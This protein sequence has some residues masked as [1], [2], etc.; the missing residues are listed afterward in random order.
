MSGRKIQVRRVLD[1]V[2]T[3]LSASLLSVSLLAAVSV[4]AAP[5]ALTSQVDRTSP[6]AQTR[7]IVQTSD[8]GGATVATPASG[9]STVSATASTAL[10]GTALSVTD[11]SGTQL[12]LTHPARR[13]ISLAPHATELIYAAGGGDWLVGA[14]DYS[15]YPDAAKR[16]PRVGSNSALDLEKILALRPD[17]IVVWRHG[18]AGRQIDALKSLHIPLFFSQPQHLDDISAT[19]RKFGTLFGTS[20]QADRAAADFDTRLAALRQRYTAR[21]PVTVFYQVWRAP[22]MT[23]GGKQIVSDVIRLC[24]GRNVFGDLPELAPTV[25]TEAVLAKA[26]QAIITPSFGA[27]VSATP[28][29][30]LDAWRRWP[31]IPA[32]RTGNLFLVQGDL[33]NRPG[34]RMIDGAEAL[35]ADLDQARARLKASVPGH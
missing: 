8:V 30:S 4:R 31:Q 14:V 22:L 27:S 19:L 20:A 25:S 7:Q 12:V 24:G 21:A 34:P 6:L 10:A 16:L 35:C 26:P 9:S 5:G 18:N 29:E 3:V 23:L 1:A 33:L 13:I 15:D 32:V 11:D 2:A 17:L 28:L